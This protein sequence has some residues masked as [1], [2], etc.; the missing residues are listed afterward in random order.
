[1]TINCLNASIWGKYF[2]GSSCFVSSVSVI[3]TL[4]N[5]YR[6]VPP[7]LSLFLA[8]ISS[9]GAGMRP[10]EQASPPSAQNPPVGPPSQSFWRR[11]MLRFRLPRPH[12]TRTLMNCLTLTPLYP[13]SVPSSLLG[14]RPESNPLESTVLWRALLSTLR[15]L[16]AS[17]HDS[18]SQVHFKILLQCNLPR[19]SFPGKPISVGPTSQEIASY[20]ASCFIFP[21]SFTPS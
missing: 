1:M 20:L 18:S 11:K 9:M 19:D 3:Y 14:T 13:A 10:F 5:Y 8:S 17:C 16:T 21:S 4:L 6:I 7:H 15:C 12:R 2:P